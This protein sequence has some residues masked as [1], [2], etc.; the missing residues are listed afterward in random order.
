VAYYVD[1]Q[2]GSKAD[3]PRS[4]V[5]SQ[6]FEQARRHI[7]IGDCREQQPKQ[8]RVTPVQLYDAWDS[9]VGAW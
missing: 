5:V 8:T 9:D 1:P 4:T 6:I 2:F 7:D 3:L